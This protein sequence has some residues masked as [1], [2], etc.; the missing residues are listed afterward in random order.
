MKR[1]SD[2]IDLAQCRQHMYVRSREEL[3]PPPRQKPLFASSHKARRA[4]RVPAIWYC[5]CFV[6]RILRVTNF[7]A[8]YGYYKYIINNL[9][10]VVYSMSM[11]DSDV[12]LLRIYAR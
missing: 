2:E 4:S 9:K 5:F 1:Q 12:I 3:L 11:G 8:K 10:V 7:V 6:H